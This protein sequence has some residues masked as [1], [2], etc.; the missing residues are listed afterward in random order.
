M[1]SLLKTGLFILSS[2]SL[3]AQNAFFD[4]AVSST[5]KATFAQPRK[6][7]IN[8]WNALPHPCPASE[9]FPK[10]FRKLELPF[11]QASQAHLE[12]L[13]RGKVLLSN[14]QLGYTELPFFTSPLIEQKGGIETCQCLDGI[15]YAATDF[16]IRDINYFDSLLYALD[17]FKTLEKK[18]HELA[19]GTTFQH[20][21]LKDQADFDIF[22][23]GSSGKMAYILS[24]RGA[25]NLGSARFI[26]ENKT[27][28]PEYEQLLTEHL[29]ILKSEKQLPG[30]GDNEF[31]PYL[32]FSIQLASQFDNGIVG[33]A[34]PK[35]LPE[36]KIWGV[37]S[38]YNKGFTPLGK[39][40][41]AQ[42]LS[43]E[44]NRILPDLAG[45]SLAGRKE[46]YALVD[47]LR[48]T[49]DR[50][51]IF[52]SHAGICGLNEDDKGYQANT[53]S[54]DGKAFFQPAHSHLSRTDLH[55]VHESAGFIGISLDYNTLIRGTRFESELKLV[56]KGSAAERQ[57][58]VKAFVAQVLKVI[59]TLQNREAWEIIG[60]ST[61]FDSG[62]A[63]L[64]CYQSATFLPDF[65]RDLLAFFQQPSDIYELYSAKQIPSFY[66][67]LKPEQI[68]QKLLYDNG[69][70]FLQ[71]ALP[72]RF[73]TKQRKYRD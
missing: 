40:V 33:K 61:Q 73:K 9:V 54:S 11:A 72:K 52:I 50:I 41:L 57:I 43:L 34:H 69:A 37:A 5:R 13:A 24:L 44:G 4:A 68:V 51:P 55:E 27:A 28:T 32:L 22:T 59:H 35:G 38:S 7:D 3:F 48:F 65:Q 42:M 47:S 10:T 23:K 12:A 70:H 17:Y 64:P 20:S 15:R 21:I 14:Q 1:K 36:D 8:A 63:P 62:A 39:K 16:A 29:Q 6:G 66:Y 56:E 2:T 45:M 30:K 46:Y 31:L 67:E 19:V 18:S 53:W 58:I 60:I 49:G 26:T 25:H 71:R